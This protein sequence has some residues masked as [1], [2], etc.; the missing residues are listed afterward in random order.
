MPDPRIAYFD[1]LAAN[2]DAESPSADDMLG[3]LERHRERLGFQ[4]GQH[5][6]ELG[7]G[8]GKT[9]GWLVEAVAPGRV[10]AVDFAPDMIAAAKAKNIEA[11][12]LCADICSGPVGDEK[13]AFDVVFCF[14]CFPH[15]RDQAAG[16]ANMAASMPPQGRLIIMHMRGSEHINGFHAQLPPPICD[17]LL[18]TSEAQWQDLLTRAGLEMQTF[19]DRDDLFFLEARHA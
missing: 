17:D 8:T 14:H 6:L 10:T 3:A 12:F 5:L 11:T 4:P 16:L 2:W 19:I 13:D 7:C 9:T 15:L 18:P 1:S